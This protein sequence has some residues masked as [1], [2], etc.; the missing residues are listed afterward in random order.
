MTNEPIPRWILD[1]P[2]CPDCD[3]YIAAIGHLMLGWNAHG[4]LGIWFQRECP[5]CD[6][7]SVAPG[8]HEAVG[9]KM[10]AEYSQRMMPSE[11][12]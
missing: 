2:K 10:R 7:S 9:D 8:Q 12:K 6:T 4:K 3:N 1:L 5:D 11:H